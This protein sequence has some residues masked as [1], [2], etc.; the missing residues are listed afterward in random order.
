MSHNNIGL[1]AHAEKALNEKWAYVYATYGQV[2]TQAVIDN[3]ARKY[4]D[5]FAKVYSDGTTYKQRTEAHALDL[6]NP[7]RG[8]DCVGLIKSYLWWRED[9]LNP[10]YSRTED[11]SAD[12]MFAY[13]KQVGREWGPISTIP[14]IPGLLVRAKGHVGIYIGKGYVIEAIGANLSKVD[15]VYYRGVVKT[16]LKGTRGNPWT[17]WYYAPFIL[18]GEEK[19]IKPTRE[20]K[21][22]DKGLDVKWVQERLLEIGGYNLG[23]NPTDGSF[24]QLT[25]AA[26]AA[27]QRTYGLVSNGVVD[28]RTA[29]MLEKWQYQKPNTVLS[30][31]AKG[32]QV[33]WAQ[34]KLI[35]LC[36]DLGVWGA[37]GSFGPTTE[38]VIKQFQKDYGLAINGSIETKTVSML[39]TPIKPP[40]FVNPY[41]RPKVT[42]RRGSR[43]ENVK[44]LQSILK[45]EKIYLGEIDGSYGPLTERAVR[46]FQQREKI[47]IDGI[48]GPQT[49][50]Y[51]EKYNF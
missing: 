40:V 46:V 31:G 27:F 45:K 19:P 16:P 14:E 35:N 39:E 15:G 4:P 42:L 43:G 36:Y 41:P 6:E 28:L 26:I 13:A 25:E 8:A 48:A 51:L 33:R 49:R 34:L 50:S 24:G 38:A 22:G 23:S 32:P 29:N 12:G 7:K 44:W 3:S 11:K 20:L 18:Y 2:I 21:R 17:E 5:L 30:R 37:D 9:A 47:L 10:R 1:I